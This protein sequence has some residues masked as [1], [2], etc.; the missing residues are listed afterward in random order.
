[1]EWLN[2]E[3]NLAKE[4][5]CH[6][7]GYYM[8]LYCQEIRDSI[9]DRIEGTALKALDEIRTVVRNTALSD[10]EIVDE[11]V[12]ILGKYGIDTGGQHDF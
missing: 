6:Q 10:F 7:L 4:L 3:M 8:Y 2:R 12:T 11:I 1:M 9:N 5:Y